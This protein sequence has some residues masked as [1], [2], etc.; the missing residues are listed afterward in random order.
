M[1]NLAQVDQSAKILDP[2]CGSGTILQEA[3]LLGYHGLIGSDIS[4]K[5]IDDTKEN[6]EWLKNSIDRVKGSDL[7]SLYNL[8]VRQLSQKIKQVDAITAEPY[9]G[10]PLKGR[11]SKDQ[12][13]KIITDLEQLYIDAF[14]EFDKILNPSGV[15][16]IIFP[17]FIKNEK[18]LK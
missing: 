11:E 2:F 12:I 14:K 5:A 9:L 18:E 4:K 15:V 3:L 8:D 6:L 7:P 1:I 17:V 16:V 13:K 10:P